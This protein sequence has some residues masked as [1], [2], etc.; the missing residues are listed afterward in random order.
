MFRQGRESALQRNADVNRPQKPAQ[1]GK[2]LCQRVRAEVLSTARYVTGL[3][4]S[5][6]AVTLEFR[7]IPVGT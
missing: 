6:V 5:A 3:A 7:T 4:R 1:L 2:P